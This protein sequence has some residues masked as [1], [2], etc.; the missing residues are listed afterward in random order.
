[1]S[2]KE[3]ELCI[4]WREEYITSHLVLTLWGPPD[5]W[6]RLVVIAPIIGNAPAAAA[7][8]KAPGRGF[9]RGRRGL[10]VQPRAHGGEAGAAAR[11]DLRRFHLRPRVGGVP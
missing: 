1:M 4:N 3:Y 2:G 8:P 6:R 5:R 7:A 11:E 9:Q 10:L